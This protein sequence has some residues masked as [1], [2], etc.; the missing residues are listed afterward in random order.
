MDEVPIIGTCPTLWRTTDDGQLDGIYVMFIVILLP[1][2]LF[3]NGSRI[4][5]MAIN[6]MIVV[7]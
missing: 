3:T 5:K 7:D 1:N 2:L 6:S 4:F